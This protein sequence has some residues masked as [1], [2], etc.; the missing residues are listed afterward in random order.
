MNKIDT[1]SLRI[2]RDY[3]ELLPL[4]PIGNVKMQGDTFDNHVA[5]LNINSIIKEGQPF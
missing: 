2:T 1:C 3:L 5:L 4:S